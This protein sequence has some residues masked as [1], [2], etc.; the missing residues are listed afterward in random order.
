[1]TWTTLFLRN[2]TEGLDTDAYRPGWVGHDSKEEGREAKVLLDLP[3]R[4]QPVFPHT[5]G[6]SSFYDVP[7][8]E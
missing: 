7:T 3:F 8:N 2:A 4:S 1:M 5:S 6:I